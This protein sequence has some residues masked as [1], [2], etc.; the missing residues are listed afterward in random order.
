VADASPPAATLL[1]AMRDAR[2]QVR[3][4]QRALAGLQRQLA[5]LDRQAL[6]VGSLGVEPPGLTERLDRLDA[7]LTPEPLA[8]HVAAAVERARIIDAPVP[9][10]LI[11]ELLPADAYAALVAAIPP[12]LYFHDDG[13]GRLALPLPPALAPI[14]SAVAWRYMV[15]VARDVLT[16]AIVQQFAPVLGAQRHSA[17]QGRLLI[18]LPGFEGSVRRRNPSHVLTVTIAFA[19]LGTGPDFGCLIGGGDAPPVTVPF[20]PNSALVVLDSAGAHAYQSIP[21]AAPDGTER[22]SYEFPIGP[23]KIGRRAEVV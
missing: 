23:G 2:E 18:R 22:C 13:T 17:S 19:P 14:E 20:V 4:A 10:A 6:A 12:R 7:A 16:P 3:V 1:E 8:R 15:D 5:E 11:T 9:H 21:A